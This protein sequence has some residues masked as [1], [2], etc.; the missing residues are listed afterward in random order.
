MA[1]ARPDPTFVI[2]DDDR[3]TR[4]LLRMLLQEK[5]YRV[6]AEAGDGEKA[7]ELCMQHKPDIIF[8]DIDMPQLD[9]HQ[10]TR[11]IREHGLQTQI[12]TISALATLQNV[13]QAMEAGASSFVVK[14]FNS[15]KVHDAVQQCMKKINSVGTA[16][17]ND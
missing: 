2:A 3:M 6:L 8:I 11:K 15:K 12:I 16:A 7:I 5:Q 4:S 13:Q 1:Y 9:G 10:A 17:D 14:P